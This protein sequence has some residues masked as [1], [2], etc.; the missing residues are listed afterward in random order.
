MSATAPSKS[1]VSP[2][3]RV[4]EWRSGGAHTV[5]K[6]RS[7]DWGR[8][9]LEPLL[10]THVWWDR[11]ALALVCGGY[12]ASPWAGGGLGI[13]PRGG[14]GGAS[15]FLSLVPLGLVVLERDPEPGLG[16]TQEVL[17]FL[18]C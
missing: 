13:Y 16:L 18:N 11:A 14:M 10:L 8:R 4:R 5:R 12:G 1:A 3:P 17:D 9:L 2:A 7:W 15:Q 6:S